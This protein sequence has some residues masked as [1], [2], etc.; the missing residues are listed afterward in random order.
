MGN[1]GTMERNDFGTIEELPGAQYSV[2]FVSNVFGRTPVKSK[3]FVPRA[4][5]TVYSL[6]EDNSGDN[7]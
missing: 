6:N 2:T 4:V 1:F 7:R 3:Q 5:E